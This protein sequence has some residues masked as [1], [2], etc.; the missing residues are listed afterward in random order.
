[1]HPKA[2]EKLRKAQE[3]DEKLKNLEPG[4]R[5]YGKLAKER[6][7][8][9]EFISKNDEYSKI[10]SAI[11]ETE[12]WLKSSDPE[13][14]ELG[15]LGKEELPSQKERLQ[16]LDK[17][18]TVLLLPQDL[19]KDKSALVE[20]R[21]GAGGDE[22]ALFAGD[23]FRMYS[24]YAESRHWKIEVLSANELGIGGYKEIIFTVEGKGAYGLLRLE[25]GVHRVQRVPVT[26]SGGRVHT[27][28]A[29]VAV[30]PEVDEWDISI[31]EKDLKIDVY[32][33]SG[34]GGQHVNKTESAVRITHLPSGLVV[35]CQDG[36]SQ[37]QNKA[38]AMLVLKSRLYDMEEQKRQQEESQKRKA[39]IGT[40]DRSEKIRTYNFQ[41]N[42]ITDHR[43]KLTLYKLEAVL[44]GDI[45]EVLN[46][47]RK[48]QE[49]LLLESYGE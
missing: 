20:I 4:D 39:Q 17:E 19:T 13:L 23:L 21:A 3:L 29:S 6:A 32:R 8:Y 16:A 36:R 12:T 24:R 22:A 37:I 45:N 47:L 10:A 41:E 2:G 38:Q 9:D 5:E 14:K 42:R 11:A 35:T 48:S 28:T 40:G 1:M 43:I 31:D 34:A 33:A 18:I 27:S 7:S 30:M 49:M 25:S 46:E 26:E 15:E 44:N